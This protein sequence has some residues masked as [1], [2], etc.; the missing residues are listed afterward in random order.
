[1]SS[2]CRLDLKAIT[3][4]AIGSAVF[5]G[6]LIR[7]FRLVT[8]TEEDRMDIFDMGVVVVRD[9]DTAFPAVRF[10]KLLTATVAATG[11][12]VLAVVGV[13]KLRK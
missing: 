8:L 9:K 10:L 12:V 2:V 13:R 11:G 6:G 5:I 1:M 7:G 4:V 3:S